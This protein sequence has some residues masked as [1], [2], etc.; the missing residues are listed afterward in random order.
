M[1]VG[2]TAITIDGDTATIRMKNLSADFTPV[3]HSLRVEFHRKSDFSECTLVILVDCGYWVQNTYK[4]CYQKVANFKSYFPN[5]KNYQTDGG[6]FRIYDSADE[7][8][9]LGSL[10]GSG[11]LPAFT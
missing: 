8:V 3:S 5:Y 9:G 11:S 1:A 10:L 2:I 6:Y 7:P 4:Y